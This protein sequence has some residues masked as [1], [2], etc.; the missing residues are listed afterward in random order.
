AVA[1][2]HRE[3]TPGGV[4][5]D[6]PEELAHQARHVDAIALRRLRSGP[7]VDEQAAPLHALVAGVVGV[8]LH[9]EPG[10]P[11]SGDHHVLDQ[12]AL[13][14]GDRA[15]LDVVHARRARGPAG[16]GHHGAGVAG[17]ADPVAIGVGLVGVVGVGAV[18]GGIGLAV[19]V[20]VE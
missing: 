15:V 1:A 16:V 4:E 17:V 5:L 10:G 6:L 8:H 18:V 3:A 2:E 13:P 11:R 9:E 20:L 19:A 7:A 12:H 14:R